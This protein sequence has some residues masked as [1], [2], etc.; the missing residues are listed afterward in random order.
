MQIQG[1]LHT[2]KCEKVQNKFFSHWETCYIHEFC[3]YAVKPVMQASLINT[4]ANW[5]TTS[6]KIDTSFFKWYIAWLRQLAKYVLHDVN[7]MLVKT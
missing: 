3:L 2:K 4:T 7:V 5:D 6:Q 1:I